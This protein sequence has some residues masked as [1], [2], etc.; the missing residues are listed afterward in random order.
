MMR[1]LVLLVPAAALAGLL[2]VS[3][4]AEEGKVDTHAASMGAPTF[5]TY[6]ATC[7]GKEGRGDGPLAGHLRV[8]PPD[9]TQ[10]AKQNKGEFPWE[11]VRKVVD[12]RESVKGHGGPDMPVWGD[13]FKRSG[14]GY[15]E[16]SVKQRIEELTQ[17]VASIQD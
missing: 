2:A 5:R 13:A 4:P 11:L 1:A 6:C 3:A 16:E 10:L 17:F 9:L 8:A 12:G 7:H 14:E 15:S